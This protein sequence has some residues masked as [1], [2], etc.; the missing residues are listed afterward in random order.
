MTTPGNHELYYDFETYKKRLPMPY[1]ESNSTDPMYYSFDYGIV[2]F[3]AM[4]TEAPIDT[5]SYL[6]P[7]RIRH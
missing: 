2:H 6:L 4:N 1:L 7:G 5:P 3:I